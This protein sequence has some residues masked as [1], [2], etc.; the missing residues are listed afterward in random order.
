MGTKVQITEHLDIDLE[1]EL[2]CCHGCGHEL[3]SARENYK[4]GC[5]LYD[6]DPGTVYNPVI[7]GPVTFAPPSEW[8][9]IVEYYCPG[10]GTMIE[11]DLLPPGHPIFRDIELDIDK[12]KAKVESR[13]SKVESPA[14]SSP[15]S[16]SALDSRPLNLEG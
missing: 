11:N 15:S 12:L 4:E 3:I 16:P 14:P 5:L 8:I 13:E 1:K 2:W 9:R 6:R 10:C 7:T